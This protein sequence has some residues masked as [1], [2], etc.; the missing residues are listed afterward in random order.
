MDR[1]QKVKTV[2]TKAPVPLVAYLYL[3]G[4]QVNA[5][6]TEAFFERLIT[7]FGITSG[8]P[9]GAMR[10]FFLL[11]VPTKNKGG[12]R[13][14]GNVDLLAR[15]IKALNAA[16]QG[17]TVE[18]KLVWSEKKEAFPRIEVA[19]K[20]EHNTDDARARRQDCPAHRHATISVSASRARF[21]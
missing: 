7:G 4:M 5:G 10:Q 8:D 20:D 1:I 9:A 14:L 18:G 2:L 15:M 16:V 13:Q 17:D 12:K 11:E 21:S 3:A 6:A 19:T